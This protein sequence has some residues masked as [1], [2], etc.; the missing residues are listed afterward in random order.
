MKQKIGIGDI[1]S[2]ESEASSDIAC[3]STANQESNAP[4]G[5]TGSVYMVRGS[6]HESESES[7][8]RY[9]P[10]GIQ[11]IQEN[12]EMDEA[13]WKENTKKNNKKRPY[14]REAIDKAVSSALK[15]GEDRRDIVLQYLK[16]MGI[17]AFIVDS[18]HATTTPEIMEHVQRV[19][20]FVSKENRAFVPVIFQR[21]LLYQDKDGL[22]Y[23]L[24]LPQH[25]AGLAGR[26]QEYVDAFSAFQATISVAVL[27][28]S[29]PC[30]EKGM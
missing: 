28:R 3:G 20:A 4:S 21:C 10:L 2:F 16:L 26:W 24:V 23:N 8:A 30:L 15:R 29:F 17:T 25:C 7:N 18:H 14:K 22:L 9:L 27:L 5:G 12:N 13:Y 11:E 19:I 1:M 6:G